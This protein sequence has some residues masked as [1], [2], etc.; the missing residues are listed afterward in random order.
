MNWQ[1]F[2]QLSGALVFLGFFL[3]LG[4]LGIILLVGIFLGKK[5]P[6]AT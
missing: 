4:T 1:S 2:C 3:G 5:H 6:P